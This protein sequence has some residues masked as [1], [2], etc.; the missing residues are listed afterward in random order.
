[1]PNLSE[2]SL[3]HRQS[4]SNIHLLAIKQVSLF[5]QPVLIPLIERDAY[6]KAQESLGI[7][8]QFDAFRNTEGYKK[9]QHAKNKKN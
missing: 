7:I 3:H 5:I 1:M 2:S 9:W 6:M 4:G 8:C